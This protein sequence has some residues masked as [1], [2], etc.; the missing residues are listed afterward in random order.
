MVSNLVWRW[1]HMVSHGATWFHMVLRQV[2][3]F[4]PVPWFFS[5]IAWHGINM[6]SHDHMASTCSLASHGTTCRGSW[7]IYASEATSYLFPR[8]FKSPVGSRISLVIGR[9]SRSK[10]CPQ[11]QM[12]NNNMVSHSFKWFHMLHMVSYG[13]IW[14]HMGLHGFVT[15]FHIFHGSS[16]YR[17]RLPVAIPLLK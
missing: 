2:R 12:N 13:F 1:Y 7:Y 4:T 5:D 14:D 11:Q 16:L 10:P 8:L 15:W 3:L 6:V 9:L 17:C